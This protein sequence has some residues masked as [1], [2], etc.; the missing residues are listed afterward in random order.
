MYKYMLKTLR[1]WNET[2]DERRKLQA[3][4]VAF[5]LLAILAAGLIALVDNQ[6]GQKLAG[7]AMLAIGV[8]FV[9][10]IAW[11]LLDGLVLVHLK[12]PTVRN[13]AATST[14]RQSARR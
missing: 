2:R 3:G 5:A 13:R 10:L 4:Y 6:L 14:R 7:F 12:K 8:Y 11:T 9:N 1:Q